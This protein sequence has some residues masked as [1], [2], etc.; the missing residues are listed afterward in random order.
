M[1]TLASLAIMAYL[2]IIAIVFI[3]AINSSRSTIKCTMRS[4]VMINSTLELCELVKAHLLDGSRLFTSKSIVVAVNDTQP[5]ADRL[6]DIEITIG[7]L[8]A[9]HE[10]LA[11]GA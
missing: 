7:Q 1:N 11:L 9:L 6:A 5:L 10:R 2:T 4:P 3:T 8:T